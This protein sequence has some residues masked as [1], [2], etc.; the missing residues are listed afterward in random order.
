MKVAIISL[1]VAM[2]FCGL[3]SASFAQE[4]VQNSACKADIAKFCKGVQ[5]GQGRIVRCMNAHENELSVACKNLIA[6]EKEKSQE[7]VQ[8]C[9]ADAAK[10][11]KDVKPGDDRIINCLKQHKAELSA[12]C[13]AHFPKR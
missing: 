7:F 9:K 11:C 3:T 10:F 2:L 13:Q 12:A 1:M 5:P 4:A 6:E 8:S